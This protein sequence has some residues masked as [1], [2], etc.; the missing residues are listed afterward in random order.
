VRFHFHRSGSQLPRQRHSPLIHSTPNPARSRWSVASASASALAASLAWFAPVAGQAQALKA[1]FAPNEALATQRKDV[2]DIELSA[3]RNMFTWCDMNGTLWVGTI[4]PASG[5]ILKADA[6]R[7]DDQAITPQA[8]AITTNGPE[9]ISTATGDHIV[10]TKFTDS[11]QPT[12]KTAQIAYIE[13]SADNT[14]WTAPQILGPG[15]AAYTSGDANDP[16]PRISFTTGTPKHFQH[17][18]RYLAADAVA[19]PVKGMPATQAPVSVRFVK[20]ENSLVYAKP[21]ANGVQQ[22]YKLALDSN[23][24]TPITTDAGNKDLRT[25]PWMWLAPDYNNKPVLMTTVEQN[26][27]R[28]YK[29]DSS[30]AWTAFSSVTMPE[31]STVASPEPFIYQGKSYV[32]LAVKTPEHEYPSAI[33]IA[34]VSPKATTRLWKVSDDTDGHERI[35]PEVFISTQ[36][37]P[38]VFYNKFDPSLA[39]PGTDPKLCMKCSEGLFQASTGL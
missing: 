13:G 1:G 28:F 39:D 27:L 15:N 36:N 7:L 21:D 5:S 31:G 35:D 29:K 8:M 24:L 11:T 12:Y 10:Y 23:K 33:Y 20:G 37:G 16:K 38:V 14:T 18:W 30:G 2:I 32:S 34:A 19:T 26:E 22:V 25:V 6:I 9:W 3:A 17:A 4:D